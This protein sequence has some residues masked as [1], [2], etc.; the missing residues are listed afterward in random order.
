MRAASLDLRG[1]GAAAHT[2]YT[3]IAIEPASGVGVGGGVTAFLMK[4]GWRSYYVTALVVTSEEFPEISLIGVKNIPI[5]GRP[6]YGFTRPL[7]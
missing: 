1:S 5:D 4:T 3:A 7:K 6:I 2:E